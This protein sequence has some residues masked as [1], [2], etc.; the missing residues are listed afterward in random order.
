MVLYYSPENLSNDFL[1]IKI[2]S[3]VNNNAL[4]IF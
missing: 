4:K 2:E 1:Y 3:S